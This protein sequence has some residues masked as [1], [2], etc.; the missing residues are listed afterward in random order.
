[1]T[2]EV[3]IRNVYG[4]DEFTERI[5][6]DVL[7]KL[8]DEFAIVPKHVDRA[9]IEMVSNPNIERPG[10]PDYIPARVRIGDQT[11]DIG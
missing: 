2:P 4:E 6:L 5:A 3:F 1:M 8:L 10:H 9:D 11:I 7:D